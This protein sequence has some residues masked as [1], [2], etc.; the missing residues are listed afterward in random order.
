[1]FRSAKLAVTYGLA[2]E[3]QQPT[4]YRFF[5]FVVV[6]V[7]PNMTTSKQACLLIFFM[8]LRA[9]HISQTARKL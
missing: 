6:V 1:M 3:K 9:V 5:H 2:T 7:A 8:G 4:S